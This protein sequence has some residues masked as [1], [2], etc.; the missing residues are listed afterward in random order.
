MPSVVGHVCH[1]GEFDSL[2]ACIADERFEISCGFERQRRA[3][4]PVLGGDVQDLL[5]VVDRVA[6]AVVPSRDG[7][8]GGAVKVGS[9]AKGDVA[10]VCE[11]S[12]IGRTAEHPAGSVSDAG[13]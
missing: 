7:V 12:E 9:V 8:A 11:R 10:I 2:T 6:V 3:E 13:R 4:I 1:A 5:A